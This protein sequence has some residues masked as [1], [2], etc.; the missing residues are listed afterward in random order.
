MKFGKFD[1]GETTDPWTMEYSILYPIFK[2]GD[3]LEAKYT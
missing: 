1:M 2:K 3:I